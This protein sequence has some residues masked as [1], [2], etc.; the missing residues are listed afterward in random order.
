MATWLKD[1]IFYEI[2]PQSF[3]DTNGDG[4]GDF[5]GITAKLDYI[6]SLGCNAI[7][8]NPCFDSPFSDAGYDVRD[9]KKVAE[10]YGT[11]EDIEN[12]FAEAHK[13]DMHILLDLV[14][15]HTSEEHA[16]FTESKKAEQN[17]YS[18]RYM[19]TDGWLCGGAGL[20]YIAG[21]SPRNGA[22]IVNFFKCQPALNY[23]VLNPTERWHKSMYDPACI[24]TREAMKDVC[25]FW[26]DKGCDGFRVDM[27]DSLVK[28][29]DANKSG[30]VAVWQDILGD[31]H[32]EYPESAFVS[33]WGKAEQSI[34]AGFDMDFYLDWMGNGYNSLVR[35][36]E[37]HLNAFASLPESLDDSTEN[38]SF[39]KA[40]SK[41][42]CDHFIDEYM[43]RYEQIK[44]KGAIALI[45]GNHDT[46]RISYGLSEDEL[47]LAYAFF[48]TMPG[49]PFIYYGDEIAMKF[50][51]MASK[52]GGFTR[53]GSRTPMQWTSGDNMGFSSAPA[54]K[55]YLPVDPAENAANVEASEADQNSLLN[56]VKALTS[57]RRSQADLLDKSNLEIISRKPLVYKRGNLL[58]AVNPKNTDTQSRKLAELTGNAKVIYSI[59]I[60]DTQPGIA[61][62]VIT[63]PAQSFVVISC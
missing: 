17:E 26:L 16:W 7:W 56:T 11:M 25:R 52:E 5:N 40:D 47:K 60:N 38:N 57:L 15:G 28:H 37:A 41:G 29:D 12:L 27:A 20:N 3:Y 30:T 59:A 58:L 1:A 62:G 14:P 61:D 22:Y 8:M 2:Y 34:K 42:T 24:A 50:R 31:I 18:D 23:G 53:T 54:D 10:R 6:K 35:D 39:F 21:E 4:I 32:A 49:N 36:Y 13:R 33:E 44:D 51:S 46:T 9:Y 63:L 45:T 48:L 43:G 55:L 19:W